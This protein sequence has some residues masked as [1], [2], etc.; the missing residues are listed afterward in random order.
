MEPLQPVIGLGLVGEEGRE[1]LGL[2][3]AAEQRL[4]ERLDDGQR[5]LAAARI[6]PAL[7]CVG[8]GEEPV[9][10]PRGLVVVEPEVDGVGHLP[11]ETPQV[12]VTRGGEHR[13]P[14]GDD[15]RVHLA[16][17]QLVDQRLP[18]R[19]PGGGVQHRRLGEGDGAADPAQAGVD[20]VGHGVGQRGLPLA[21]DDQRRAPPGGEVLGHCGDELR[22]LAAEGRR[23]PEAGE[24]G[25]GL[26]QL[27]GQ[28]QGE[29]LE[30][31]AAKPQPVVGHAPGDAEA[32]LHHVEPV[33][34][35]GV[36]GLAAVGDAEVLVDGVGPGLEE[37]GVEGEDDVGLLDG[38]VRLERL[39][40]GERGAVV[41][42]V[43]R[44]R[45]PSVEFRPR[46]ALGDGLPERPGQQRAGRSGEEAQSGA[47]VLVPR[48]R[49]DAHRLAK[50]APAPAGAALLEHPGAKRIIESRQLGLCMRT[51]G[52][53][54]DGVAGIALHLHRPPFPAGGQ[55]AQGQPVLQ[56][57]GGV[58]ERVTG[59]HPVGRLVVGEDLLHRLLG[60]GGEPGQG[61]RGP[62]QLEEVAPGEALGHVEGAGGKL[63]VRVGKR[64]LPVELLLHAPPV[65]AAEAV[66][67]AG[68]PARGEARL[69]REVDRLRLDGGAR[70]EHRE[71]EPGSGHR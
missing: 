10:H 48:R 40:E 17:P 61:H 6:A 50:P 28:G 21:G 64:G 41:H 49:A 47:A 63:L 59:N 12:H 8:G 57:G 60:A 36:A 16:G 2:G 23:A 42:R 56:Q 31:G 33:Q 68:L 69:V 35:R 13:V 1:Q 32:R 62:H 20:G 26:A 11:E 30:V 71:R 38:V 5:A 4:D 43:A 7:E 58:V 51:G 53:A 44:G 24:R 55:D 29:S 3:D 27:G 67:G 14:G 70:A 39:A 46:E 22:P 52:A 65:G 25:D 18:A 45:A 37:V 19:G 54:G 15:Q 66:L 9:H 34:S